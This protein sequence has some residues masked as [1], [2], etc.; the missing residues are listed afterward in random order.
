VAFVRSKMLD[1]VVKP[2][3]RWRTP[4]PDE[5]ASRLSQS[6]DMVGFVERLGRARKLA[7]RHEAGR[8]AHPAA[9]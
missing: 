9:P 5:A 7:V 8:V 6:F 3:Q 4:L 1:D 2:L